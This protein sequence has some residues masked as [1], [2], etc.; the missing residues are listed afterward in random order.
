MSHHVASFFSHLAAKRV[1]AADEPQNEETEYQEEMDMIQEQSIEELSK[2]VVE[3]ISVQ[4]PII[5]DTHNICELVACSKLS[6]FSIQML[7]DMCNFY[8]LTF[9]LST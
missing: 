6:R 9:N 5:Y 8:N 1:A 2:K 7:R 3:E 4:H